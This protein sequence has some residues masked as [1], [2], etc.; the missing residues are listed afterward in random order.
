MST[1]DIALRAYASFYPE[2]TAVGG[3]VCLRLPQAPDSPMLNRVAGLGTDHPATVA[4]L[5][6]AIEAMGDV[7]F[8]VSLEPAARPDEI[9]TWLTDRG[10]E[11]GWGWMR[12]TRDNSPA[13]AVSTSLAVREI[14]S[15]HAA[16][17]ADIQRV[18][19]GLPDA[20]DEVLRGLVSTPG[21]T[22]WIGFDGDVPAAAGALFVDG[23]AAYFGLGATLPEHRGK[24]GQGAIFA[25]RIDRARALGCTSLVTET[26]ERRDEL[27]SNS[28]RNILRFGFAEADV[29]Q[30][31]F[32]RR[33]AARP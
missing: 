32:R 22:C 33:P 14:G 27:P 10:F 7:T 9:A 29:L 25:A 31:W 21:W 18:A 23:D 1:S 11:P 19:Y 30:N 15:D 3:V 2:S 5:E 17:F 28:Y 8:Y 13:P 6:A 26:G 12:F 24:G 20:V 16:E 4:E